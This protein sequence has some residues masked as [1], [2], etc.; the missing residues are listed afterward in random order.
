MNARQIGLGLC[1]LIP[2][3]L[4]SVAGFGTLVG[5]S[6]AASPQIAEASPVRNSRLT[7]TNT[8]T[9]LRGDVVTWRVRLMANGHPVAYVPIAFTSRSSGYATRTE[10]TGFTDHNGYATLSFRIPTN[11]NADNVILTAISGGGPYTTI[12]EQRVSI[13]RR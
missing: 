1:C 10:G 6:V 8:P 2:T 7:S 3:S 5:L 9:G 11:V 4:M 13:G 12:V